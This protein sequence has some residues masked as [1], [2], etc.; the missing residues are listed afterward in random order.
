MAQTTSDIFGGALIQGLSVHSM[1]LATLPGSGFLSA[2]RIPASYLYGV[3]G[4]QLM[5]ATWLFLSLLIISRNS[6]IALLHSCQLPKLLALTCN[7]CLELCPLSLH[8]FALRVFISTLEDSTSSR[9]LFLSPV[10]WQQSWSS[11]A[12]P[13]PAI[14]PNITRTE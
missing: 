4:C 11:I 14:F 13:F 8:A 12:V 1:P 9:S 7:P 3:L 5:L 6:I 2:K 10:V